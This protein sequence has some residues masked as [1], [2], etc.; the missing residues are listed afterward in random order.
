MQQ[1]S[2]LCLGMDSMPVRIYSSV[3][4][5]VASNVTSSCS[6]ASKIRSTIKLHKHWCI[7]AHSEGF[8][9]SPIIVCLGKLY[10]PEVW[11]IIVKCYKVNVRI[12]T[13]QLTATRAFKDEH[14]S[15]IFQTHFSFFVWVL[16]KNLVFYLEN[17]RS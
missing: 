8:S 1:L 3:W 12:K 13:S 10:Y 4:W 7:K 15:N 17:G 5:N 16:S 2:R 14:L 9:I 6:Y 11:K